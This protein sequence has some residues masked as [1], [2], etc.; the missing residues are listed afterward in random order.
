[1]KSYMIMRHKRWGKKGDHGTTRANQSKE[2]QLAR[3]IFEY[4]PSSF[5]I[6]RP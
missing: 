1:M 2:M 3:E 4:K 6:D 5:N